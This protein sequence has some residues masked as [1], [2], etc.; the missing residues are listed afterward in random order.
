M[1][2]WRTEEEKEGDSETA[3]ARR[4]KEVQTMS[5]VYYN[6]ERSVASKQDGRAN[7]A[8]TESEGIPGV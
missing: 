2:T 1:Q 5:A 3:E 7:S 4:E 6:G 8:S